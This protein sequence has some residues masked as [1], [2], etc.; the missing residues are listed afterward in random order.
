[1]IT[2]ILNAD[3]LAATLRVATPLLLVAL[4]AAVTL[5]AG[6]FNVA[7]EGI[8]L[9]AA[10]LAVV[11]STYFNSLLIG[12]LLTIL[13]TVFL[14]L[15]YGFVII[16]LKADHIIAGLGINM[17]AAGITSWLLQ[18]VLNAPGGFSSPTT[19]DVPAVNLPFVS[20]IPFLSA[21]LQGQNVIVYSSWILAVLVYL[22]VHRSK[23]GLQ[24]R[25]TGEHPVAAITAGISPVRWQYISLVICGV[26]CALGGTALSMGSIHLFTKGMT[27]GRGFISFAAASF[28][29]GNIPGTIFISYLFALFSSLAIRLGS[30]DVPTRFVQMIP[31]LVTLIALIFSRRRNRL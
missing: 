1:M 19:P 28:A 20:G 15:A 16:T 8:M 2:T 13:L 24:L 18:S 7:T 3:L 31:Y 25:A 6:I 9:I 5:K 12:V 4:G 14:A 26:L 23:F 29:V 21:I 11:L 10:F 27:A 22:F 17:F 30:L